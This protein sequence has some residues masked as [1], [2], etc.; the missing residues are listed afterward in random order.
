MLRVKN[1]DGGYGV[2]QV[3]W[4]IAME[5]EQGEITAL[6]GSNGMGKTTLMR[7]I[8]GNIKP[9]GG[10]L[11]YNGQE[12]THRPQTMRVKDGISMI[13]EG[14]QLYFGMTVE[15]NLL[16]GAY[17]RKDKEGTRDDLE[18]VYGKYEKR[19]DNI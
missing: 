12:I 1:L 15:D 8:A 19:I 14:R 17:T 7:T 6:I 16:M 13:P 10:Q 4:R 18:W 5:V 9:L 3:L 11:F 2:V